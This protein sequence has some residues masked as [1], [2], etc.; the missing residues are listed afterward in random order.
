MTQEEFELIIVQNHQYLVR[1]AKK[2][3]R[4]RKLSFEEAED[5]VQSA[6]IDM[7]RTYTTIEVDG[8]ASIR[9]IL[10]QKVLD[11][12]M[13]H[14]RKQNRRQRI[15]P[16]LSLADPTVTEDDNEPGIVFPTEVVTD[17]KAALR[18]L[19]DLQARLVF[20]VWVE[21]YSYLEVGQRLGLT[22]NQAQGR[23]QKG[24][25]S[26]QKILASYAPVHPGAARARAA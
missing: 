10:S 19:P 9:T 22:K 23:L 4:Q 15:V 18:K 26:L 12:V 16:Q 3:L 20:S 7:V 14:E 21:G 25:A 11:E 8:V 17:V 5:L 2:E 13:D 24:T 1:Y 6:M